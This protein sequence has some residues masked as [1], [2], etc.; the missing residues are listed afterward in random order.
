MRMDNKICSVVSSLSVTENYI[1]Y[2]V[3]GYYIAMKPNKKL[4]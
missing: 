3:Q 4:I 1:F 2:E